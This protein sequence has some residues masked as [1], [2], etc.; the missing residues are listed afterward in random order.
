MHKRQ[1]RILYERPAMGI[2]PPVAKAAEVHHDFAAAFEHCKTKTKTCAFNEMSQMWCAVAS[3]LPKRVE[4]PWAERMRRA[5]KNR[6]QVLV[7]YCWLYALSLA[8][9]NA[10]LI[11]LNHHLLAVA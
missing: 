9:A 3:Y 11:F 1:R 5:K 7:F 8:G 6:S 2:G 4:I 10:W